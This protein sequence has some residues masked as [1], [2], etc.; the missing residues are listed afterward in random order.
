MT[1]LGK[2]DKESRQGAL[3]FRRVLSFYGTS[4][5]M[6]DEERLCSVHYVHCTD[7]NKG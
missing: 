7:H 4:T 3:S 1:G 2:T 5:E 6:A